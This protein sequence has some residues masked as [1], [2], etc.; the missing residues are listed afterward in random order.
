MFRRDVEYSFS[1]VISHIPNLLSVQFFMN[2]FANFFA[3]MGGALN[4]MILF[5][6]IKS[7]SMTPAETSEFINRGSFVTLYLINK[8]SNFVTIGNHYSGMCAYAFRIS[9][10]CRVADE[11]DYVR[12]WDTVQEGDGSSPAI[13]FSGLDIVSPDEQCHIR[14]FDLRIQKGQ[15]V[16]ITGP[17]GSGKT[18]LV[19]VL[20][21]LWRPAR[22]RV[23]VVGNGTVSCAPQ[24]ATVYSGTLLEQLGLKN[25][26]SFNE[27]ACK[28]LM[29]V[30]LGSLSGRAGG[31][32]TFLPRSRWSE[33][34]SPGEVQRLVL[35][36]ILL[37]SPTFAILDEATSAI[38][39]S[40]E[41][42]IYEECWN[43]GITTITIGHRMDPTLTERIA[44]VVTL[45]GQGGHV[46][47]RKGEEMV[48]DSSG[49]RAC[50]TTC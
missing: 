34:L 26:H 10:F 4:Y 47:Q 30:K 38:D 46:I 42:H 1:D 7:K 18:S 17:N 28:A 43:R 20:M 16:Y 35:A 2:V 49:R 11:Y 21:R 32:T 45:D 31:M 40:T 9:E 36:R 12:Q 19:R 24:E 14:D 5:Y 8:L 41:R 37:E 25:D 29:A 3:Y 50:R 27:D 15:N 33:M 22:G 6:L 44:I 48:F 23:S 39:V 13:I